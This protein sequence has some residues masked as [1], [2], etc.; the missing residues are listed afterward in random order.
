MSNTKQEAKLQ[1]DTQQAAQFLRSMAN[2]LENGQANL[3]DLELDWEHIHQLELKL[4]KR[5]DHVDLKAKVK[6]DNQMQQ[7]PKKTS[8]KNKDSGQGGFKPLKKDMQK[9]FQRIKASQKQGALPELEDIQA[10]QHM[11]EQMCQLA[12]PEIQEYAS[13][14][15]KTRLL[16]EATQQ[17]NHEQSQSVIQDLV[18]AEKNCHAK[19]K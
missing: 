19:F 8:T 4:R 1:L 9:T 14:Q 16:L 18:A 11:A 7:S 10:L 12:G 15:D 13:F 6:P 3:E 5:E 17:E 2:A